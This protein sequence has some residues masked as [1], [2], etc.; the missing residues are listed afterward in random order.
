L[1]VFLRGF[2]K[3]TGAMAVEIDNSKRALIFGISGQDGAYLAAY[4]MR[5]GYKVF[6][7][8]RGSNENS[9]EN[10]RHLAPDLLDRMEFV[11]TSLEDLPSLISLL[12]K[13]QPDEIYNLA[14]Q[15][16]VGL[17]FEQPRATFTSIIGTTQNLLDAIVISK[18]PIRFYNASSGECFG[19][20]SGPADEATAFAP[21]S[22]YAIAKAAAHWLVV[23]YREGR[24]LHASNGILF[25]H[26]SPLR[27]PRYVTMKV[28][29]EALRIAGGDTRPLRLGN[30]DIRRDW[31]WAPEYVDATWRMLQHE[32]DDY[33]I[34][35]GECNSLR[36][37]VAYC[38]ETLGLDWQKHVDLEPSLLRP[39]EIEFSVGNPAKA[40]ARLNWKAESRMRQVVDKMI[41]AERQRLEG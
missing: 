22:P 41:M 32:P 7:S 21:R 30:L 12:E 3:V 31:G 6:G 4:L 28:V 5:K 33:V 10:L 1:A 16:S 38:F 8:S 14:A 9:R 23:S 39:N 20:M 37:F 2:S 29:N 27:S 35:T 17:S 11:T 40:A 15:S 24:G 25:N 19:A 26:E 36:D 13:T 18:A 34:A